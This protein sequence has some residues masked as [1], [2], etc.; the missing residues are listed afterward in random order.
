MDHHQ[1]DWSSDDVDRKAVLA[2]AL[3]VGIGGLVGMAGLLVACGAVLAAGRRWYR[4]V[5]LPP[6]DLAKLKWEQAKA[7]TGAGAGAW[8]DTESEKYVPRSVRA[9]S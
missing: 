8:R 2:A 7:A 4:R 1:T 6:Q 5:D 9:N 3:L